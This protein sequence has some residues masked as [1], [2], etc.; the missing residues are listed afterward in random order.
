MKRHVLLL[1]AAFIARSA[2]AQTLEEVAAYEALI[3]TPAAAVTPI[4]TRTM[5]DVLQNGASFA[6]RYG[7]VP[8]GFLSQQFDN[9][10]VTAVLPA[11]LGSA[12]S[13]TAGTSY[14]SCYT[15]GCGTE[16][17]KLMASV[18][19]EMRVWASSMD[20]TARSP[21]ITATVNGE[22]G[23]GDGDFGRYISGYVGLPI[24]LVPPAAASGGMRF[25]P[26]IT[27]GFGFAER[28]GSAT[29]KATGSHYL[30]GGGVGIFN[31]ESNVSVDLGFQYVATRQAKTMFGLGVMLGG[32]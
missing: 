21:R 5:M 32:K 26:Y 2:S 19:G 3:R 15:S 25:V 10:A 29:A 28:T 13:L 11:G 16:G 30:V 23:Y 4:A 9:F 24:A 1:A 14:Q 17:S 7:H 20:R 8:G 27:P 18:G 12:F 31:A 6:V 22:L